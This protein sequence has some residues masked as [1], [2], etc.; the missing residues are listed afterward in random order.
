MRT[1]SDGTGKRKIVFLTQADKE[2]L[3]YMTSDVWITP[4][5]KRF[6]REILERA[7]GKSF[8]NNPDHRK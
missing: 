2:V 3:I 4:E 8:E 1:L 7:G 6:K 5:V